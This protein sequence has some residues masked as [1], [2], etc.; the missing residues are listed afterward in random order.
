MKVPVSWLRE[1]VKLPKDLSTSDLHDAFISLGFEVEAT[2][3][4]GEVSGDLLVGEVIDIKS[5][6]QFKK[7]IRYCQ[8]KI[9][10]QVRGIVCGAT[11]FSVGDKVVVALP[12]ATLPGDFLITARKT[13]DHLSDGM[14]CSE[15][16]LGLSDAHEGILV[17]NKSI[18]TGTDAKKLLGLGE[19]VFDL[20]VLPDRGYAMSMRGIAREISA[21]FNLKFIDPA[22]KYRPV[23]ITKGVTKANISANRLVSTLALIT[24]DGVNP[25]A[26]TPEFIKQR[27]N[28]MGMRAISLPVDITNYVMLELGQPLHA[29]DRKSIKGSITARLANQGEKIKTLDGVNRS[30]KETDLVISDKEKAIS[31]A[32][33]MGGANSEINSKTRQIVLEAA[34]FDPVTISATARRLA[35]TS[36][37]SKRFERGVDHQLP[38]IAAR[39]AADLLVEFGGGKILGASVKISPSSKRS[40]LLSYDLTKQVSGIKFTDQQIKKSLD[41]IGATY[42]QSKSGLNV[43]IPSWRPDLLQPNDLIEEVV[44]IYGYKFIPSTLP[45]AVSG[46]GLTTRQK[47][48]RD[49]GRIMSAMGAHEVLNYPFISK[50]D[51]QQLLVT[52]PAS[53]FNLVKISNPLNED[54]PYLRNSLIIGLLQT[55]QRNLSR[56]NNNFSIYEIGQCFSGHKKVKIIPQIGVGSPPKNLIQKEIDASLPK[57]S[58]KMAFLGIGEAINAGWWGPGYPHSWI[59]VTQQLHNFLSQI[60]ISYELKSNSSAPWH[61]VRSAEIHVNGIKIGQVGELHP[62]VCA[63]YLIQGTVTAIELDLDLVIELKNDRKVYDEIGKMP[64]AT[65]DLAIVVDESISALKIQDALMRAAGAVAQ[66]VNLFDV[67][68]SEQIGQGKKSLAFRI[69]LRAEDRTLT[70][71]DLKTIRERMIDRLKQ[72]FKASIR[73]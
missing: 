24:L 55:G 51:I 2:D 1:Y 18:K 38:Q 21:Y 13:Y 7:P 36:E 72:D 27:L 33:I 34:S 12:G 39:R 59:T 3:I 58:L 61:P 70:P 41:K 6:D 37:A 73:A 4:F 42:S 9:G 50:S 25:E 52:Q 32:G 53:D 68:A 17:V 8:V 5:L 62:K 30:L 46:R 40:I 49:C 35:L 57:Q 26:G 16:E 45:K 14:I 64:Y 63:N 71:D 54:S 65:E 67:F 69:V 56:G 23:K 48:I 66:S 11:N 15:R 47:T 31:I 20:S 44:R 60:D 29:F 19:V 22:S 10:N 43:R 28:Q